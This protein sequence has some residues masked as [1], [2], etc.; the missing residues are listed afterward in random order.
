M[1]RLPPGVHKAERA[2]KRQLASQSYR[3]SVL[4]GQV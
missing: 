1:K 4:R 2:R 3:I